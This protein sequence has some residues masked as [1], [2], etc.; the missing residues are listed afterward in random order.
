LKLTIRN[1]ASVTG[2]G[3]IVALWTAV[4]FY[5]L[6]YNLDGL[7]NYHTDEYFYVNSVKNMLDSG[8]YLTPHYYEQKRFNK[9]ILIYWLMVLACKVFGPGLY[10]LRF[11]SALAGAACIPTVYATARRLFDPRAALFSALVFPGVFL[12]FNTARYAR[13]DM[14]LTFFILIAFHF[15]VRWF[16]DEKN[17]TLNVTGF[18]LAIALGFLAKGPVAVILPAV[19]VPVFLLLS[20]KR[21]LFAESRLLLGLII[22]LLINAPWVTTML[23]M[24]GD[25]FIDHIVTYEVK[26]RVFREYPF[27]PFFFFFTLLFH[28]LPWSF[29]FITATAWFFGLAPRAEDTPG[30]SRLANIRLRSAALLQ[31]E[32]HSILLCFTWLL[33]SLVFFTLMRNYHSWYVASVSAPFAMIIGRYF[34]ESVASENSFRS[35]W[36]VTPLVCTAA[37]FIGGGLLGA[38]GILI[39]KTYFPVS[40]RIFIFPVLLW[41]GAAALLVSHRLRQYKTALALAAVV[42]VAA[43]GIVCGEGLSFINGYPMKKFAEVIRKNGS[44]HEEIHLIELTNEKVKIGLQTMQWIYPTYDPESLRELADSDKKFFVILREKLWNERF[45][46]LPL[47]PLARDLRV[48]KIVLD[49]EWLRSL[50]EKGLRPTLEADF[51]PLLLLTNRP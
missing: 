6:A 38:A 21:K 11:F 50:R 5:A 10:A 51:E 47:T 20:G 18:Y 28:S 24:H 23:I 25:E 49:A 40:M 34:A 19:A 15:F 8:D 46:D 2:E 42:Q 22:F 4:C 32:H 48:K 29:F 14:V 16:Q 1:I 9:P 12:V 30:S 26:D 27:D 37:F 7:P 36:F 13:P 41:W 45:S 35:A 43:L 31:T 17:R 3:L 39:Y 44:G 33:T